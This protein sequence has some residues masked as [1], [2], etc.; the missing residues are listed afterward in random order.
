MRYSNA[1]GEEC[2]TASELRS[3]C[4]ERPMWAVREVRE[5][6]CGWADINDAM[7]E[8]KGLCMKLAC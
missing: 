2:K 6:P 8:A 4:K 1:P 3:G 5:V 7:I